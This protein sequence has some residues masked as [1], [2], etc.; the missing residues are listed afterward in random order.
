MILDEEEARKSGKG[1]GSGSP[2]LGVAGHGASAI[3]GYE[4]SSKGSGSRSG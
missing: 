1:A 4:E 2:R 3:I